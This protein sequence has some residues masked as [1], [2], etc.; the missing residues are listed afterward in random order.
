MSEHINAEDDIRINVANLYFALQHTPEL[1]SAIEKL[2]TEINKAQDII[3]GVGDV[4]E[5]TSVL[6]LAKDS[7][8]T[9]KNYDKTNT[10]INKLVNTKNLLIGFN[11]DAMHFFKFTDAGYLKVDDEGNF[12]YV[13]APEF[14]QEFYGN[15]DYAGSNIR[16]SGCGLCT[17]C[18]AACS[19]SN[20]FFGPGYTST[21]V[22]SSR[23]DTA[24][25][26]VADVLGLEFY[27]DNVIGLARNENIPEGIISNDM[28]TEEAIE[29]LIANGY[30]VGMLY[31]V[32]PE[33]DSEHFMC[34]PA[35]AGDGNYFLVDS[36]TNNGNY[37]SGVRT[38]VYSLNNIVTGDFNN[39]DNPIYSHSTL[40]VFKPTEDVGDAKVARNTINITNEL[41]EQITNINGNEIISMPDTNLS[42]AYSKSVSEY[43]GFTRM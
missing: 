34:I 31:K 3:A 26:K 41:Y 42:E 23:P 12:S 5:Y 6:E 16:D 27:R 19:L 30:S 15:E 13:I 32:N 4:E 1:S 7:A 20:C 10:I 28:T 17:V 18:S 14:G 24:I 22:T 36:Y 38:G 8:T 21:L 37:I 33:T 35:S 29:S 11:A 25:G 40:F 2:S 39:Q 9:T 43:E